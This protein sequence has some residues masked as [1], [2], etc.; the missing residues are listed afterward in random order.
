[1]I[2]ETLERITDPTGKAVAALRQ[3]IAH[4]APPRDFAGF[5]ADPLASWIEEVFGFEPGLTG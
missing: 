1:M 4:P 5:T 2:G 3:R